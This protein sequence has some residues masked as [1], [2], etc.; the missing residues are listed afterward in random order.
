M[1]DRAS[2]RRRRCGAG[3]HGDDRRDEAPRSLNV[4]GVSPGTSA[5]EKHQV[6]IIF[7]A[8]SI[9]NQGSR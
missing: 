6:R 8:V 9:L 5:D 4:A 1:A 2:R 3:G 7:G